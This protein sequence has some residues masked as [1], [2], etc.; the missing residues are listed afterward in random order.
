MRGIEFSTAAGLALLLGMSAAAA[1]PSGAAQGKDDQAHLSPSPAAETGGQGAQ[2]ADRTTDR[3]NGAQRRERLSLS[4][5]QEANLSSAVRQANIKPVKGIDFSLKPGTIVPDSVQLMP[6]PDAVVAVLPQFRNYSFFIDEQHEIVFVDPALRAIKA[7][8]PISAEDVIRATSRSEAEKTEGSRSNDG[9]RAHAGKMCAKA[10]PDTQ[11]DVQSDSGRS[12]RSASRSATHAR[13]RATRDGGE[14]DETT[15]DVPRRNFANDRPRGTVQKGSGRSRGAGTETDTT[16][17]S[18]GPEAV[19]AGAPPPVIRRVGPP[20]RPL[21]P[22]DPGP[23]AA[24]P[25]PPDRG[26]FGL[27]GLFGFFR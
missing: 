8:V 21:R 22:V 20:V 17:G 23:P 14:I 4:S 7:R 12:D 18:A 26:P 6:V 1:Q 9:E 5:E 16:V 15:D 10:Q 13:T 3:S 27:F 11:T 25:P 19:E 2:A 24:E